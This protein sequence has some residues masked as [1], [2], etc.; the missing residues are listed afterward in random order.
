MH[1][2]PYPRRDSRIPPLVPPY[3][4]S[5]KLTFLPPN[6]REF[7]SVERVARVPDRSHRPL[8]ERTLP[9]DH[10]PKHHAMERQRVEQIPS[11]SATKAI[12]T[13]IKQRFPESTAPTISPHNPLLHRH[14][15]HIPYTTSWDL[16][17]MDA[18]P[19]KL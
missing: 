19:G 13:P 4:A 10:W 9:R 8:N 6:A 2:C 3:L 1:R 15:T 16:T 7:G 17:L 18:W 14:R 12:V 5:L 11:E